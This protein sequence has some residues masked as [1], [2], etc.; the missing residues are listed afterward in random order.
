MNHTLNKI[1]Q[2]SYELIIEL[3]KDDLRLYLDRAEDR[4]SQEVQLDGFRK[5]R[6]PKEMVRKKV[7]EQ[8][9]LETA[10]DMAV[11]GSLAKVLAQESLEVLEV[12]DLKIQENSAAKLLFAI[13]VA[14]FPKIIFSNMS[15]LKI[16][17][18]EVAV[19]EDEISKALDAIIS[20]RARFLKKSGCIERGDRAEINIE[21][22]DNGLPIEGGVSKNHPLV[23]GDGKFIPGFEEQLLGMNVGEGK[24]FNLNIPK[25]FPQKNIAGKNLDFK[26][27]VLLV[28]RVE[29]PVLNDEF[30]RGLGRFSSLDDLR[31]NIKSGLYQEK[32]QKEKQRLRL[33]IL[34]RI[35]DHS[36]LQ[37][38]QKM[39]VRQLDGMIRSFDQELHEKGMELSIYLAHLNKTEDD[40]R[41]DWKAEA[42]RQAR[43]SLVL[44]KIAKDRNLGPSDE[45]I[46]MA[47]ENAIQGLAMRGNL[48]RT[49]IN[50]EKL[51][52]AKASEL[53]TEKTFDYLENTYAV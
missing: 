19:E 12:S 46:N 25:T 3:D 38:G 47:M 39:I 21:I 22:T 10:L 48:D 5:G 7:G 42:E 17:R 51:R 43:L 6:A 9:I 31:A 16:K 49:D 37:V 1:E 13:N 28:E 44:K 30:A 14:T 24:D 45:E 32:S 50:M 4:I 41:K 36:K 53:T 29:K 11:D 18:R 26:V 27:K 8:Y 34:S 15:G 23:V 40:L 20:S 2:D 52:E 33:E 35:A